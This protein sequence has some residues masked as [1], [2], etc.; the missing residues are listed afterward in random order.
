ML[1]II[2]FAIAAALTAPLFAYS[3]T[4]SHAA[5]TSV[6]YGRFKLTIP[7]SSLAD[8]KILSIDGPVIKFSDS[9]ILAGTN[10]TRDLLELPVDF[11]LAL[12]PRYVLGLESTAS[13]PEDLRRSLEGTLR[14]FGIP[15]DAEIVEVRHGEGTVYSA[16][17]YPSCL[18]FATQHAQNEHLL[19][20]FP[21]GFTREEIQ[22]FL[23]VSDAE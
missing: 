17:A 21:E 8:A 5:S 22:N 1:R 7:T 15:Q 23:E 16:C 11:N 6:Y 20:L 18:F 4:D 13:L 2:T 12:Y 9:M 14:S 19:M 3:E 10:A